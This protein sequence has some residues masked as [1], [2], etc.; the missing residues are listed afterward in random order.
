MSEKTKAYDAAD[1]IEFIRPVVTV[2]E[3]PALRLDWDSV[4]EWIR[5][6]PNIPA[7]FPASGVSR[8]DLSA[9]GGLV[10]EY[11]TWKPTWVQHT[12]HW[13]VVHAVMNEVSGE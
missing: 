7:D 10:I 13:P 6:L 2:Q 12:M 5:S 11:A 8:I 9:Q 3:G 1:E 4:L